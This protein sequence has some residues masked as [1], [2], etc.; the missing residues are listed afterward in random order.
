MVLSEMITIK[1]LRKER[2]SKPWHIV[3]DRSSPLGN[4]FRMRSEAERDIVCDKY[5]KY[6]NEALLDNEPNICQSLANLRN[7]LERYGKIELFCWCAPKR[8]HAETIK[9]DWRNK[10]WKQILTSKMKN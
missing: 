3:V 6:F 4:P 10:K 7:I 8:C 1:N 2:P 9:N 5:E